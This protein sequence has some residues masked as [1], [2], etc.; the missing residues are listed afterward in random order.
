MLLPSHGGRFEVTADGNLVFSKA[1]T[2][3]HTTNEFVINKVR[4]L[5]G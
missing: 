5:L 4:K 2:H 3:E 1:A